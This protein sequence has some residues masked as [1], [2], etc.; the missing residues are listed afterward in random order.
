MFLVV[1]D[2]RSMALTGCV[3]VLLFSIVMDAVPVTAGA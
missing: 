1:E 3:N 2:T